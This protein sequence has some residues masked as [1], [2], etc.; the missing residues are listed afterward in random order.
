MSYKNFY[1]FY[2]FLLIISSSIVISVGIGQFGREGRLI[3]QPGFEKVYGFQ[4]SDSLNIDAVIEGELAQYAVIDDPNPGGPP[5]NIN[6]ILKLPEF[7]EPGIHYLYLVANERATGGGMVGGVASVRVGIPVFA[8]YP[9]K[10]PVFE[11]LTLNDG[12]VGESIKLGI[13][14]INHGEETIEY[15]NGNISVY[16]PNGNPLI[17]LGTE[18]K[19]VKPYESV[20][21]YSLFD[22]S[23]FNLEP[24]NYRAV[25][26]L[27]TEGSEYPET[28]EG[29]FILGVMNVN[30]IGSTPELFA[31]STNKY[32]IQLESDWS[33]DIDNVYARINMPNGKTVRSPN[34]DLSKQGQGVKPGAI[35][36]TYVETQGLDLG[37]HTFD[38]T[39]F[40]K[41]QTREF[42]LPV[43]II[44]GKP[45][46]VEKPSIITPMFIFIVISVII[47]LFVALYFLVFR[48][49]GGR[50]GGNN[51][52]STRIESSTQSSNDIRP[53]SL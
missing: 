10:K 7:L 1:F 16:D 28:K 45:P 8:L 22:S 11:G 3:F 42:K 26:T 21:L 6:V 24:G 18:S 12:N 15:S 49:D 23:K 17:V 14:L 2:I 13:G 29:I 51:N 31:N 36:E 50:T 47:V 4:L 19:S 9:G 39:I 53:P 37:Q 34:V 43:I 5:R 38:V 46:E 33:G 41:G 25:G 40:Y 27:Y 35:I 30:I 48:K 52:S 20:T 44:D 32:H